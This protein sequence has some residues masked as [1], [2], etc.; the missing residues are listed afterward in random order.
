MSD[1]TYIVATID[2]DTCIEDDNIQKRMHEILK[3]APKITGSERDADVFVNV[4]SGYNTTSIGCDKC[5]HKINSKEKEG[6]F[7]CYADE[8]FECISKEYQTRVVITIVGN[9]RD[10]H[11]EQTKK[12]YKEFIKYLTKLNFYIENRASNIR[13]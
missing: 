2:V 1:W 3:Y 5:E 4:L 13:T 6:Y 11:I 9:L 7:E 10:R 12:E 8:N